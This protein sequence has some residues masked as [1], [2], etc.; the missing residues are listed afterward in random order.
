L[1]DQDEN[2]QP[3]ENNGPN[4][5]NGFNVLSDPNSIAGRSAAWLARLPWGEEGG[6][7]TNK[8][9]LFATPPRG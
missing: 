9:R 3:N 5:Q 1:N 4:E 6:V 8:E 2:N 7:A